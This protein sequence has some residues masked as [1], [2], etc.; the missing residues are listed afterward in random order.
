MNEQIPARNK[1]LLFLLLALCFSLDSY[2]DSIPGV[3]RVYERKNHWCWAA[4]TECIVKY[5][6]PSCTKTQSQIAGVI[7]T[8]NIAPPPEDIVECLE[9]NGS[10]V[11]LEAE[12]VDRPLEWEEIKRE[13]DALCPFIM[14]IRWN[15]GGYHCNV[16]AGYIG[17]ESKIKWMDPMQPPGNFVYR[18]YNNSLEVNNR[19]H[20]ESTFLTHLGTDI[21]KGITSHINGVQPFKIL[22]PNTSSPGNSITFMFNTQVPSQKT[23]QVF[24]MRGICVFSSTIDENISTLTWGNARTIPSGKYFAILCIPDT[25]GINDNYTQSFSFLK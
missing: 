9:E 10:S 15:S 12:M 20:W 4:A 7:T 21:K 8:Q 23:F 14:L 19:G 1:F 2:A 3:P 24:N 18:S 5:Y 6:D 22:F 25:K 13:S 17:G 16:C 11:Q